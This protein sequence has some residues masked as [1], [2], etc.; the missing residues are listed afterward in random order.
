MSAAVDA[1]VVVTRRDGFALDVTLTAAPGEIVAVMGPS[2]AGKSTLLS[3]IAGLTRIDRGRIAIDGVE[4]ATRRR[5][6]TPSRRGV[7]LLGQDPRLFPHMTA[8]ENVAFGPRAAGTAA[9]A[10]RTEADEWLWHVGLD[11]RGH[12]R[13][14]QL[15]G[16]QQQRV[17]LARALA[18]RP[19]LV[20]LDEPL[21]SLDPETAGDI[22]TLLHHQ[23]AAAHTTA[24][25]VT[26]D[27]VDAVALA[28]RLLVLENGAITQEGAV[29]DVLAAPATRFVAVAAGVNRVVGTAQGGTWRGGSAPEVVLA[30]R[31]AARV[32]DG[33]ALTVLIRPGAIGLER[34]PELSWTGA[35][36]LARAE[37][38]T[39]NAWLARVV[40]LEQT[41]AGVRVHTAEP[42]VAVDLPTER[43]ADLRL[44]PG[45]PVRLTVRPSDVR[46]V[47]ASAP[48]R[49][50]PR[51]AG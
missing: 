46:L 19:R 2:G 44:A 29:R 5:H 32:A 34:P 1:H 33:E 15:S 11:G 28:S 4:V 37:E 22:R 13:P 25:V 45:D 8:R 23:L 41:P 24:L 18:A 16:G 35:L 14:A 48:V 43:A 6:V 50:R 3:A 21:T 39:P 49:A 47:A 42:A 26:H 40:R 7:V 31:A 9:A 30:A 12:L 51:I 20:L 10:A 27:A 36:R 38:V 17:A